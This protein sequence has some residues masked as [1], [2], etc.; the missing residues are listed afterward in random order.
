MLTS[1]THRA[2]GTE[3]V[4][5]GRVR[6]LGLWIGA[7]TGVLTAT[8]GIGFN[9]DSLGNLLTDRAQQRSAYVE[10]LATS[11]QQVIERT[12]ELA[13]NGLEKA[14]SLRTA[15]AWK[16]RGMT[17]LE[18]VQRRQADL[19]MVWLRDIRLIGETTTFTSVVERVQPALQHEE[20][21]SA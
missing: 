12:Y 6:R 17:T 5:G 20:V 18:E 8:L 19:A 1:D 10:L 15:A 2:G 3:M 11:Q 21:R 14:L 9:L 7:L 4:G 13:W 16:L